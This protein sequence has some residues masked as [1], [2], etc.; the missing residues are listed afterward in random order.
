VEEELSYRSLADVTDVATANNS[1]KHGTK[2]STANSCSDDDEAEIA[3]RAL[4]ALRKTQSRRG[5]TV[6]E[7]C[8]KPGHEL[9]NCFFNPNSPDD[10]RPAKMLERFLVA[11]GETPSASKDKKARAE[12]SRVELARTDVRAADAV[13]GVMPRVY[14]YAT[15]LDSGATAHVFRSRGSFV[16]GSLASSEPRSV[17]LVDKSVA[18]A[19][20]MGHVLLEFDDAF[21]RLRS[22]LL[23]EELGIR[24]DLRRLSRRHWVHV[25]LHGLLRDADGGVN[26]RCVRRLRA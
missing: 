7:F 20:E 8:D 11:Q 17:A 25:K 5:T 12:S 4:A 21:L 2:T 26:K 24:P 1:K 18:T 14:I 13:A 10:K 16:P 22:V 23:V 6:C 19:T 3:T 9:G 15:I